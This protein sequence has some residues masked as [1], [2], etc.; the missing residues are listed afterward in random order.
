MKAVER[1]AG[2]TRDQLPYELLHGSQAPA[3]GVRRILPRTP[4]PSVQV[5]EAFRQSNISRLQQVDPVVRAR[6]GDRGS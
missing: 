1:L 6:N 2:L 3:V 4:H 5:A